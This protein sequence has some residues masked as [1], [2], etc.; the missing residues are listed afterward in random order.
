MSYICLISWS[1][2]SL[3]F[4][5]TWPLNSGLQSWWYHTCSST[6]IRI[7]QVSFYPSTRNYQMAL[8]H[9]L[10]CI[11][12]FPNYYSYIH[13]SILFCYKTI[14]TNFDYWNLPYSQTLVLFFFYIPAFQHT[15]RL[16]FAC[17]T[18]LY[19]TSCNDIKLCNTVEVWIFIL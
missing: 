17:S 1:P 9:F 19:T 11:N 6:T 13:T 12:S 14:L 4:C 5:W 8:S 3:F 18:A 16:C 15:E 10:F 7:P 2:S